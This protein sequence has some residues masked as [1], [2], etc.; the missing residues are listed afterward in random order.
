MWALGHEGVQE[1]VNSEM[2]KKPQVSCTVHG[3]TGVE[4]AVGG[5]EGHKEHC[6]FQEMHRI[7]VCTIDYSLYL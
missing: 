3:G 6:N 4:Q 5:V 1:G 2:R 7:F